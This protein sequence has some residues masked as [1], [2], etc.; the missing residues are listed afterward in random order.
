MDFIFLA[1]VCLNFRTTVMDPATKETITDVKE[2]SIRQARGEL[3]TNGR[4]LVPRFPWVR[5]S[6][7]SPCWRSLPSY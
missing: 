3:C 6:C 7:F 1:D 5:Q 4:R 2:I